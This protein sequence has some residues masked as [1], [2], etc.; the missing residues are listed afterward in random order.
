MK[1]LKLFTFLILTS[2]FASAQ[3]TYIQFGAT[4]LDANGMP[5]ANHPVTVMDSTSNLMPGLIATYLTNSAGQFSDSVYTGVAGTMFMF[6]TDSCQTI[7]LDTVYTGNTTSLNW[8][9]TF[10]LCNGGGASNC[11]YTVSANGSPGGTAWQFS[12]SHQSNPVNPSTYIWSFGDG[13][14]GSG[15]NPM[16]TY[17]AAGTYTYCLSVDNC[18]A[19]CDTI[20]V[21]STSG[22]DATF[23]AQNNGLFTEINPVAVGTTG[24]L[25]FYWGDGQ[26]DTVNA[27]ALPFVPY[28]HTYAIA[29]TYN[30]CVVHYKVVNGAITC[31]DSSCVSITV[32]G[33]GAPS[34]NAEF[35]VDTVNSFAGNVIIW[36]TSTFSITATTVTSFTWDFG[37]GFTSTQAFPSHSYA[38]PGMYNVCLTVNSFDIATQDSC[39]STFCDSLGVDANGNLIYKGAQTGWTLNVLDPNSI[40]VEEDALSKFASFPNPVKNVLHLSIPD[41]IKN[42]VSVSLYSISGVAVKSLLPG[43]VE[44]TIDMSSLP[45]GMYLLQVEYAGELKTIKVIKQD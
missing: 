6:T 26:L 18:P 22:C 43:N 41:D 12:T 45:N 9:P 15:P 17:S 35:I 2:F 19:V 8:Y 1:T 24:H 39:V 16:H 4:V 27:S 7:M 25:E 13:T 14:T 3:G 30:I 32:T 11:N 10:N 42:N 40:G 31:S 38:N 37:D 33:S 34:C 29:G 5:V 20:V 23:T 44:S 28:N 21:G 36:N